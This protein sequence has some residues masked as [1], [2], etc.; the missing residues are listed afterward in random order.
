MPPVPAQALSIRRFPMSRWLQILLVVLFG[1]IAGLLYGWYLAPVEYINTAPDSLHQDYKNEY[2]LMV[3]EAYQ[4]HSDLDIAARQLA[5]LGSEHPS[6]IIQIS[7][8]DTS[9][10][11]K[12]L[13][14]INALL[15][16][17]ETWQP[18]F[19]ESTP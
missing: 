15:E 11:K 10:T 19:G 17:F 3:A 6:E 14:F 7:L 1:I 5:Q 12:E 2:I 9:F 8:E 18:T 4:S 13:D 16:G